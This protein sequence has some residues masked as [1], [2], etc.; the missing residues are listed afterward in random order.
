MLAKTK[1]KSQFLNQ[2]THNHDFGKKIPQ[3]CCRSGETQIK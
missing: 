3:T 2:K 1:K